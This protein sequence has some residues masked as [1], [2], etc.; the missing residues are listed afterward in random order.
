[1]PRKKAKREQEREQLQR[2]T[3]IVLKA[4]D[5]ILANSPHISDEE[6]LSALRES[7]WEGFFPLVE[8]EI[9]A[10][11]AHGEVRY[12][13]EAQKLERCWASKRTSSGKV[14]GGGRTC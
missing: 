14:Q 13:R 12:R 4:Y 11:L 3:R 8:E 6:L 10:A 5:A 7:F 2:H 9:I 1:M